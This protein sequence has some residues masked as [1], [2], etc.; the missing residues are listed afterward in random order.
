MKIVVILEKEG[1]HFF[2]PFLGWQHLLNALQA[3]NFVLNCTMWS[4][5]TARRLRGQPRRI[6]LD[7]INDQRSTLALDRNSWKSWGEEFAQ[8]QQRE[9]T[10]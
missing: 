3:A 4:P 7:K 10:D 6:W 5:D 2:K 8:D 9:T 1:A